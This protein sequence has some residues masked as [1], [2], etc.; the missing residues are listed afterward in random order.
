MNSAFSL[1]FFPLSIRRR[2]AC[3][4]CQFEIFV[5]DSVYKCEI[6]GSLG[7]T[8]VKFLRL[9]LVILKSQYI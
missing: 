5:I 6:V 2:N 8:V 7:V 4:Y 9:C 3:A 1:V